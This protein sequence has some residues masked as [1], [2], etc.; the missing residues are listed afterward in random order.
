M[1]Q[2]IKEMYNTDVMEQSIEITCFDFM[3][4]RST[5]VTVSVFVAWTFAFIISTAYLPFQQLV[6]VSLS[7]MPFIVVISISVVVMYYLLP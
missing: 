3:P 5:A 2:R 6:G 1:K 7:Y 4:F